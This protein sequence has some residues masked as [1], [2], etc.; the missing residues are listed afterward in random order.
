MKVSLKE[1]FEELI[2]ANNQRHEQRF[3]DSEKAVAA[4]LAAVKE[5]TKASFEASEKAIVKS[6]VNAEKWRENANEWRSAMMDRESRFAQREGTD[7][8]FRSIR[9]ELA[10]LK[11]S[12]DVGSGKTAN[13]GTV[14]AFVFGAIGILLALWQ[15][16]KP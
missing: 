2:K 11:E 7:N 4:A 3:S 5:Q 1:H 10:S 15:S 12:R 14:V 16:F 6:D 8:E 9:T 13:M